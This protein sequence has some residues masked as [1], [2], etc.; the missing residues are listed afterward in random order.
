M[1][2]NDMALKRARAIERVKKY[3]EED[4]GTTLLATG[5]AGDDSRIAKAAYDA[6]ARLFEPNHPAVVLARGYKGITNMHDAELVRH[7]IKMDQMLE[8]TRGVR[9]V[10]GTESFITVGF[11]GGFTELKPINLCEEDFR[12]LSDAG[13]DSIHCHKSSLEDLE[14]LISMAHKYG[15]LVDCYIG[16]NTDK[17]IFGVPAETDEEIIEAIHNLEDIGADFIGMMT[18]MSYEGIEAGRIHPEVERRVKVLVENATAP[19]LAE[20]GINLDNF[21]AFKDLGV[22]IL[23]VGTS[24]DNI[25]Q[26]GTKETVK[27]FLGK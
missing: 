3:I 17:H 24:I 7:E 22:N 20:G 9:N 11:P 1:F 26:E 6:G 23:V 10:V 13:A 27:K 5:I 16:R 21:Q 15:L 14:E 8:V 19:T 18:G 12:R 2:T 25:V 4:G